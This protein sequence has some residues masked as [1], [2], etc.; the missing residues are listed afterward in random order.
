VVVKSDVEVWRDV[1]PTDAWLF[2][3]LIVSFRL[4]Y[5]CGPAGVEV[6]EPGIYV[7]RPCVNALGMGRGAY[8]ASLSCD[9]DH[10][11]PGSFWCERFVGRHLSVDYTD[12]VPVQV[13]EGF[14]GDG[15]PLWRFRRWEKLPI[16]EAPLLPYPFAC[17]TENYSSVNV[18]YVGGWPIEVHLRHD[19]TFAEGWSVLIP[20]WRDEIAAERPAGFEFIER[21]DH[22]RVGFFAKRD[23]RDGLS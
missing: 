14:R 9:T 6:P 22:H 13:V 1:E 5:Q 15:D 21:P 11:P 23:S 8:I 19:P 3:K 7:V 16:T 20:V 4:G 17:W 10:L 2:D 12:G 18:E